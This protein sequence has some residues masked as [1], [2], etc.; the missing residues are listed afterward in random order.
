MHDITGIAFSFTKGVQVGEVLVP[1]EGG[2]RLH[3]VLF[4]QGPWEKQSA[5]FL[6]KKKSFRAVHLHIAHWPLW[7]YI[8]SYS[9]CADP[10]PFRGKEACVLRNEPRGWGKSLELRGP[11]TDWP[12][13]EKWDVCA[14]FLHRGCLGEHVFP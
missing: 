2:K 6:P 8:K 7:Y 14:E 12:R 13:H 5:C 9:C 4:S 11:G 3:S 1:E 10:S